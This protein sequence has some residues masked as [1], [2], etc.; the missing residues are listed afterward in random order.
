MC[1]ENI[2]WLLE[3]WKTAVDVYYEKVDRVTD[4]PDNLNM[5]L[6]REL[7]PVIKKRFE[8]DLLSRKLIKK[9]HR[10]RYKFDIRTCL[11]GLKL[12]NNEECEIDTDSDEE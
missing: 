5:W 8:E 7:E 6:G 11:V 12:I 10:E 3:T 2:Y 1:A 4:F 9:L